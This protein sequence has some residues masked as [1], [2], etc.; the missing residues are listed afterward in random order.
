[1][2]SV[3]SH[4]EFREVQRLPFCYLCGREF[5]DAPIDK[6]DRKDRDH[7]PSKKMFA[8]ADRESRP[9]VL[10]THQRCNNFHSSDDEQV[11]QLVRLMH[12][13]PKAPKDVSALR[14]GVHRFGPSRFPM[15]TVELLPMPRIVARWLRGFHAALYRSLQPELSGHISMPFPSS[16]DLRSL[17]D[18]LPQHL[19]FTDI[20][21][22]NRKVKRVDVIEAFN[23]RVRYE[24]TWPNFDD[25][26]PFCC[27]GL[28][29]Y[30]WKELGNTGLQPPRNCVGF[31]FAP[32]DGVPSSATRATSIAI[33]TRNWDLLDPFA[34]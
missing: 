32:K 15:A 25:G 9:L 16:D 8:E 29:I 26:R 5:D 4:D 7:V 19:V 12:S 6:R 23:G 17:H 14:T 2:V 18:I 21:K 1:M 27:F 22:Q 30:G 33:P 34:D 11:N 31:Y 13:A 3:R 24:C 20:L 10:P 28:D